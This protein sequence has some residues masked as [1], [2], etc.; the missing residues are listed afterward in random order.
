MGESIGAYPITTCF[1]INE[2]S[3]DCDESCNNHDSF[4]PNCRQG[5]CVEQDD[6]FE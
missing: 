1:D 3:V 5:S 2:G 4:V 6:G